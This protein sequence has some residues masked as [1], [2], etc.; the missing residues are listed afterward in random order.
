LLVLHKCFLCAIWV[1]L[2]EV[3]LHAIH[4]ISHE[5]NFMRYTKFSKFSLQTF[6]KFS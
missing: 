6:P 4:T 1:V 2:H 5:L 3:Y